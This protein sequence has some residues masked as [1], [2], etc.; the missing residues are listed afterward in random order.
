MANSNY[1][2]QFNGVNIVT[3]VTNSSLFIDSVLNE[4]RSKRVIG[5]DIEWNSASPTSKVATL[6]LCHGNRCIIIQLLH[7]DFIPN[8]LKNLLSDR[9]V[10]FVGV[11]ITQDIARL[12]CD[13]G[14]KCWY[15]H[16]LGPLA[17]RV[18]R[19]QQFSGAGL[20]SLMQQVVGGR[21]ERSEFVTRSNWGVNIL[22]TEQ[23]TY[24]TIDAYA[25]FAIGNKLLGGNN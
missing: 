21:M 13:Y 12:D 3:T 24:A 20:V 25:S 8:S 18:Y 9:S 1:T 16:E 6:Q 5:L 7:L 14:L 11:G 19:T 2:V 23:I 4:F 10:N 17:D 22:N 15:G